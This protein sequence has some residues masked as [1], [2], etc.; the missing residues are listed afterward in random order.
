MA[1]QVLLRHALGEKTLELPPRSAGDPVLIGRG[2]EADVRIPSVRAAA[3]HCV[4]FVQEGKWL[5][6]GISGTTTLNGQ[7]LTRPTP[8]GIGDVIGIGGD[9]SG[10]TIRIDRIDAAERPSALASVGSRAA[11]PSDD[12]TIA[13]MPA[14]ASACFNL[15]RQKKTSAG[16]AIFAMLFVAAVA[17]GTTFLIRRHLNQPPAAPLEVAAPLAH[18]STRPATRPARHSQT[19]DRGQRPGNNASQPVGP[20]P[21]DQSN[22]VSSGPVTPRPGTDPAWDDLELAHRRVKRQGMAILQ[23]D[24]YRQLHPGSFT[25]QLDQYTE[26]AVNW[27]YWQ[28]V[29]H[30]WDKRDRLSAQIKLHELDLKAQPPGAFHDKLAKEKADLEEQRADVDNELT[31]D[32]GYTKPFP[33]DLQSPKKLE[34]LAKVRDPAKYAILKNRMLRYVRDHHGSVWWEGDL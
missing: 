4:L 28:Y 33:P 12:D 31:N 14:V 5:V 23:F 20:A 30:L 22:A 19:P 32:L 16:T 1:L 29:S 34:A 2:S 15:P 18:P 17:W 26:D 21:D 7:P 8:L 24:E 9:A 3:R 13:W 27:L 6:E 11:M 10:P 25:Q